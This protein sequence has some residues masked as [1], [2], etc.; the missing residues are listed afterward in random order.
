M[1]QDHRSDT[2]WNI[3]K[4]SDPSHNTKGSRE[5]IAASQGDPKLGQQKSPKVRIFS[6]S[7]IMFYINILSILPTCLLDIRTSPLGASSLLTYPWGSSYGQNPE[8][9][10]PQEASSSSVQCFQKDPV[11]CK[12]YLSVPSPRWY[13]GNNI[14]RGHSTRL[15]CCYKQHNWAP[16]ASHPGG[17][18]M[19]CFQFTPHSTGKNPQLRGAPR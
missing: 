6:I 17:A 18:E 8:V 10:Y 15:V 16:N 2:F 19:S 3:Q 9:F 1:V 11:W 13:F 12:E 7:S 4:V 5:S 14:S